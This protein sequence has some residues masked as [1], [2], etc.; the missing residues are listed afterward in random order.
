M[1]RQIDVVLEEVVLDLG[2]QVLPTKSRKIRDGERLRHDMEFAY[3]LVLEFR[4]VHGGLRRGVGRPRGV[5]CDRWG[6]PSRAGGDG[7]AASPEG[8]GAAGCD[9]AW[10]QCVE[11]TVMRPSERVKQF[12]DFRSYGGKRSFTQVWLRILGS[13]RLW[14][15]TI[16]KV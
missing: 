4:D 6:T 11:T 5:A 16:G 1:R 15:G 12:L 2:D 10:I 14:P 3:G 9:H 13:E 7:N 8:T